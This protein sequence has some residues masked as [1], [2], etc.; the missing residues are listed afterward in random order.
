[1]ESSLHWLVYIAKRYWVLIT[2]L[3]A[4]I[5]LSWV[6]LES[7]PLEWITAVDPNADR[8]LQLNRLNDSRLKRISSS[9]VTMDN[10][11]HY[12]VP[13][14]TACV[15]DHPCTVL[16]VADL[17]QMSRLEDGKSYHSY[18]AEGLVY[19]SSSNG[20]VVHWNEEPQI[21]SS[22]LNEG[23]RGVELSELIL[24]DDRLYTVDDRTGIVFEVVR[25]S[26]WKFDIIARHILTEGDG[27][28]STKGMKL[29]WGTVKDNAMWLGSF[30]K[31]YTLS[32][33]SIK[34]E[35]PL[36]VAA[37]TKNHEVKRKNWTP[38][39]SRLREITDSSFPGYMIH[40][41]V[42]WSAYHRK[43][44]ILPRR[45][46]RE[47]YDAETDNEKGTNKLIQ[48]NESFLDCSVKII[49]HSPTI[50]HPRR[51]YS[52][53]KILPATR[54]SIL[55]TLKSEEEDAIGNKGAMNTYVQIVDTE[56]NILLDD[57]KL[58]FEG[59]FEGIVVVDFM[60]KEDE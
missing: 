37:I 56:G 35:W 13:R 7:S 29:E 43:W 34:N 55:I 6:S 40:E 16:A 25:D 31:E 49:G 30:G 27:R 12:F 42:E 19:L 50:H 9:T 4:A 18:M 24:F 53:V 28:S 11:S 47:E 17:D 59:K 3:V 54:D 44:F 51:G 38:I 15:E 10:A 60:Q 32:D 2:V 45:W 21:I 14:A 22:P 26:D 46:S 33:G 5:A 8:Y 36:W 20:W 57:Q 39:Y 48:C 41:A 1:M 23:N 58:P 52:S